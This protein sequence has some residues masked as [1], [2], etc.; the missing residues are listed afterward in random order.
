MQGGAPVGSEV[1][2]A[3][4]GDTDGDP[5]GSEVV[6]E[7]VGD[8]DGRCVQPAHVTGQLLRH[9]SSDGWLQSV[10]GPEFV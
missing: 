6:G 1:V 8:T 7:E 4:V 2:G 10:S 3:L 5:V 9:V